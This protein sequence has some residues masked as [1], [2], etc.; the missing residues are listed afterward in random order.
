MPADGTEREPVE[1]LADAFMEEY[2]RGGRPSVEEYAQRHPDLADEIRELFPALVVLEELAPTQVQTQHPAESRTLGSIPAQ[3]GDYRIIRELGRGGMGIVYEAEQVSLA[4]RVALKVLPFHAGGNSMMRERLRREALAAASLDHPNV[5]PVYEV[6]EHDGWPYFSMKFVEGTTLAQRIAQGPLPAR[7]A[8]RLLAPVARGIAAAHRKGILHR[9]LKPSNILLDGDGRPLV[10]DFGLAKTVDSG[11]TRPGDVLGT[12]SYMAPEQAAGRTTGPECDVY[13]LGA[14]L[15][16]VI[17]GRPPFHAATA[18]ETL[19]QVIC[20]EPVPPRQLNRAIDRDAEI[21]CLK[22]LAKEPLRRYDSADALAEDLERYLNGLPIV[23]RP[24]GPIDRARRWCKRNPLAALAGACLIVTLLVTVVAYLQT[25]RAL[26][27]S[28]RSFQETREA[29]NDFFTRVSEEDLLDQPGLQPLRRDLLRRALVYYQRFVRR[30][31]DDPT[32]KEELALTWYRIGRIQEEVET[33]EAALASYAKAQ[34]A[35]AELLAGD[36]Q[37]L[38]RR[39]ALGNTLNAMGGAYYKQRRLDDARQ[40]FQE[41][42]RL[43][44]SL[45]KSAPWRREF[46]RTLANVQMNLG[47]VEKLANN[48]ESARWHLDTAQNLRLELLDQDPSDPPVQ[49][50]YAQGLFNL[51]GLLLAVAQSADNEQAAALAWSQAEE[52]FALARAEFERLVDANPLHLGNQQALALCYLRLGDVAARKEPG[53]AAAWY[54]QALPALEVL[55][56]ENP[57]VVD[58]QA[59]LGGMR[60][61]WGAALFEQQQPAEAL[62]QFAKSVAAFDAAL[63]AR[64]GHFML[65][66]DRALALRAQGEVL[67]ATGKAAAGVKSLETAWTALQS[68]Q[69]ENQ[70]SPELRTLCDE[71][72][73]AV[74]AAREAAEKSLPIPAPPV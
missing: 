62:D 22:C 65:R 66:R 73:A 3:F 57:A 55:A 37:H 56:R 32:L 71:T 33:L 39:E 17:T 7:E 20:D 16:H 41:A 58:Y 49:R 38:A 2:R 21:I 40:A 72:A 5:V 9:D 10:S 6:G 68:L 63:A 51:G 4:R 27:E 18:M 15:Y 47:L 43:R 48:L 11:I 29:V 44:Q 67:V 52:Q 12:P 70:D 74:R 13:G 25:S 23:A 19:R 61:Q 34:R 14:M 60:L 30:H 28:E 59:A 26:T 50:D 35:Q 36:P 64:P 31:G 69:A 45:V 53:Q 42:A 8:A 24:T 54:E 46:L 1:Q